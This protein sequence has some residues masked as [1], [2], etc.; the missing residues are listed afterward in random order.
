MQRSA[1]GLLDAKGKAI[2][3]VDKQQRQ[4][5]KPRTRTSSTEAKIVVT[6]SPPW[7][8]PLHRR[9]FAAGEPAFRKKRFLLWRVDA[10]AMI[11]A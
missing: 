6:A 2:Q 3:K 4:R 1:R 10:D 9:E 7:V 11:Q 8:A 5:R